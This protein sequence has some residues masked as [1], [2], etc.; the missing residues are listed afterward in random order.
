MILLYWVHQSAPKPNVV[1][2]SENH[3]MSIF[4]ETFTHILTS[5]DTHF[6]SRQYFHNASW[7]PR[8][9]RTTV[10][11][12]HSPFLSFDEFSLH[13]VFPASSLA[14]NPKD[15]WA[16]DVSHSAQRPL[17]GWGSLYPGAFGLSLSSS[18]RKSHRY[19]VRMIWDGNEGWG[20]R[21]G[22]SSY[23]AD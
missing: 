11:R 22:I 4:R 23:R 14:N 2:T 13:H 15:T 18:N 21:D 10:S 1:D 3:D 5:V 16:T 12:R 17:Y 7:K 20:G 19:H 8:A 9:F 6:H